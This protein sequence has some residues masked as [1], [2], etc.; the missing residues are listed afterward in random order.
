[1]SGY[2]PLGPK[3]FAECFSNVAIPPYGHWLGMTAGM[4]VSVCK[5]AYNKD[6]WQF[7][8]E[9]GKDLP[10]TTSELFAWFVNEY[11]NEHLYFNGLHPLTTELATSVSIQDIRQMLYRKGDLNKALYK[12]NGPEILGSF[13]VDTRIAWLP[14][15]QFLGSYWYQVKFLGNGRVGFRIDNDTTL[16]SGS[17]FAGRFEDEGYGG[18]V[19]ELIDRNPNI[20][21]ELLENVI[22]N[23]RMISILRNRTRSDTQGSFG[24]GT[25]YQ[26]FAW[27]EKHDECLPDLLPWQVYRYLLDIQVWHNFDVETESVFP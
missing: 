1:M 19:E 3:Y 27:T 23:S 18:S 15:T 11:G 13:L 7:S 9:P 2:N 21:S 22:K 12:F 16:S 14:L 6:L 20:A 5:L 24:G 4:A 25:M 8:I 26:T 17:H 10:T